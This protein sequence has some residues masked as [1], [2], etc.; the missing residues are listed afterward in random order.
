MTRYARSAL[1]Q[2]LT[3]VAAGPDLSDAL[4]A[5]AETPGAVEA[6]M[7]VLGPVVVASLQVGHPVDRS[8]GSGWGVAGQAEQDLRQDGR[9][10]QRGLLQAVMD[11]GAALHHSTISR[12]QR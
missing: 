7:T 6:V 3:A 2:M 5:V 8:G 11:A 9:E 10:V 4:E 1:T 12:D